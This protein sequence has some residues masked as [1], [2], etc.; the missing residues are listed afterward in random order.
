MLTRLNSAIHRAR[1]R[2][3][4][5]GESGQGL[6]EYA[7]IIAVVSLGAI[8]SLT[9]LKGSIT[10][11][12]S[13]AGNSIALVAVGGGGSGGG[14]GGNNLPTV[15]TNNVALPGGGTGSYSPTGGTGP[16]GYTGVPGIY[17]DNPPNNVQTGSSC[18]G[19]TVGTGTIPAGWV[20]VD[21]DDLPP[22]TQWTVAGS[23]GSGS[24]TFAWA[25][26]DPAA[27]NLPPW[28]TS[29]TLVNVGGTAGRVDNGDKITITF[30]ENVTAT[31]IC[32]GWD[33]TTVNGT[34]ESIG[35]DHDDS[36]GS[37]STEDIDF[38]DG[39]AGCSPQIGTITLNANYLSSSNRSYPATMSLGGATG[40]TLVITLTSS[41][42]GGS[43]NTVSAASTA[44]YD[45]DGDINDTSGIDIVN[46]D[47]SIP[48]A[49][50]F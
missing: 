27:V 10:G 8:A 44:V 41:G 2:I 29:V 3:S 6:V 26:I 19:I 11:L 12:F 40:N 13:K 7:L 37:S 5:S 1:N 43:P 38:N 36:S 14:G 39:G 32:S 45:P 28:V 49:L 4:I 46:S 33:G 50:Q 9:F 48:S 31:S 16:T 15:L 21:N 30:S 25:C 23:S 35:L 18:A 47:F 22:D 20:W 42:S 17:T 24:P 34:G